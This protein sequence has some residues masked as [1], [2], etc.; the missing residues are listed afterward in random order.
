MSPSDQNYNKLFLR[1]EVSRTF[2]KF[3]I[4]VILVFFDCK[5]F[6]RKLL[7]VSETPKS[8]PTAWG[9]RPFHFFLIR[10][11]TDN[12]KNKGDALRAMLHDPGEKLNTDMLMDTVIA[13]YTDLNSPQIKNNQNVK[14]HWL[15]M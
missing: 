5:M 9:L 12:E 10:K 2:L 6:F 11:K 7:K 1:N 14:G 13:L 8:N 15:K 4:G 3:E